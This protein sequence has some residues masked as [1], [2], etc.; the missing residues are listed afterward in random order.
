MLAATSIVRDRCSAGP[1]F[2]S[3]LGSVSG[4]PTTTAEAYMVLRHASGLFLAQHAFDGHY[5]D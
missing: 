3:Y 1:T 2:L 5:N 4:G